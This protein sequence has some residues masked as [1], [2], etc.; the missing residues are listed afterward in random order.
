ALQWDV[1]EDLVLSARLDRGEQSPMKYF[2]IPV[3]N[4]GL[5]SDFVESNFNVGD[6]EVRYEDDSVRLK[7]DWRASDGVSLQA[8]VFHLATDRFWKNSEFYFY[9]EDARLIE[10]Y[11]PLVLGHD[12]EHTGVR[13]S[14]RFDPPSRGLRA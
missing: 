5:F 7:A 4:G 9:D 8:E 14:L 2:G 3:V 12:M 13:T 1:S 10:R 11:D 6:A